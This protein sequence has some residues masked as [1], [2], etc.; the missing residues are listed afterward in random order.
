MS[1]LVLSL[2][3]LAD[4]VSTYIRGFCPVRHDK[5]N[6]VQGKADRE[7][8]ADVKMGGKGKGS[9]ADEDAPLRT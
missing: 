2:P 1:T 4:Q 3:D 7:E 5:N 8:A 9:G 6:K